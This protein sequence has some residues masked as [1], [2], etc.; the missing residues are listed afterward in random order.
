MK[1]IEIKDGKALVS[2]LSYISEKQLGQKFG[3]YSTLKSSI[4]RHNRNS[5]TSSQT[6]DSCRAKTLARQEHDGPKYRQQIT[7][8]IP[9][10][11]LQPLNVKTM[12]LKKGLEVR[13][14]V[15]NVW[16]D[17]VKETAQSIMNLLFTT[18]KRW[19]TEKVLH[20]C[21]ISLLTACNRHKIICFGRWMWTIPQS[22][23]I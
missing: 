12:L 18:F 16:G 1:I 21:F 6:C 10:I 3:L 13:N 20:F 4:E 11:C 19:S 22:T 5:G 17:Y 9:L 7:T 15:L 8:W 23:R 2:G 14:F